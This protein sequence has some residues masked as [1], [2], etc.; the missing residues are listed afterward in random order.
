MSRTEDRAKLYGLLG[1]L[2]DRR[3][4][5]NSRLISREEREKFH[6]ENL[7]LD[8]NGI[9]PVPAYFITPKKAGEKTP[10]VIFNHSHGGHYDVGRQELI[11][12]AP[13]LN[14]APYANDLAECGF[15]VLCIDEWAFG[16]RRGR[17]ETEIFKE[18][19][20]KGR[21]MWGMMVYDSMRA[22]DYLFTRS[23]VD[24]RRIATLGMS[25]GGNKA[26][27]LSAVDERIKVCVDICS[28]T[29]YDELIETQGIDKHGVYYYVP[30][31]LKYFSTA[32]IN[33]L[34]CPRPHLSMNG[35]FDRITPHKGL[36][37]V[38]EE[39]R[40][41]YLNDNSSECFELKKYPVGHYETQ[42]MRTY[43]LEFI[44]KWL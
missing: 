5:V 11:N 29:E 44:K 7:I 2:P 31:L 26:W 16:D 9:E 43:A 13:Y 33:A 12:G 34:I 6:L 4:P 14:R 18:M 35:I 8:L 27:W 20:W 28:M 19:L 30:G 23:D 15:S 36:D 40:N 41:I 38:N 25:M 17:T 1:D 3:A 24:T 39:L 21:V 22:I 42:E 32:R 10:V 37:S